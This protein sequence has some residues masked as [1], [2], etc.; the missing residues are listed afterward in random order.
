MTLQ[1]LSRT[2]SPLWWLASATPAVVLLAWSFGDVPIWAAAVLGTLV[3]VAPAALIGFALPRLQPTPSGTVVGISVFGGS[4]VAAIAIALV[5]H[6]LGI[7]LDL[8]GWA[9]GYLVLTLALALGILAGVR[10]CIRAPAAR[11]AT[12]SGRRVAVGVVALLLLV[13]AWLVAVV[14]DG[15]SGREGTQVAFTLDQRVPVAV[16][17]DNHEGH[18]VDYSVDIDRTVTPVRVDDGAS[19]SLPTAPTAG[20]LVRV[21][22]PEV[23]RS[24]R[25]TAP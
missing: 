16:T 8:R 19:V 23:E 14:S 13:A 17:L 15:Q 20:V 25:W 24:L 5:D 6:V 2:R 12:I 3:L 21:I 9:L 7:T 1:P 22:W 18:A 11:S 10:D 4:L